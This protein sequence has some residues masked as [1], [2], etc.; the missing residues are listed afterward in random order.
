[1]EVAK[2]LAGYSLGDADLLRRAMGKKIKAEMDA[3]RER[4]VSGAV[5]RGLSKAQGERDLRPPRQVRRLRLQQEPR[6]RLR[7]RRL[8]DR[9]P[10]GEPSGRVPR[11]VDDARSLDNTDKLGEFRREAQR[12]GIRV[13]PPSVNRSGV[14]FDVHRRRAGDPLRARRRQ[15][16]R[17]AGRRGADRGARRQRLSRPRATSPGASTRGSSTSARSRASSRPGALDELEPDRARASAAVD[18]MMA[19]PSARSRPPTGGMDDMFGG[20]AAADVAAAHPA[21]RAVA[22]L[23]A[24]A[25][26][27]RRRRLLP[28]RPPARR[29]SA[30]G[31]RAAAGAE[32]GRFLPRREGRRS[33]GRVAAT[34]LDRYERRTKTGNKMGI[35][36]L[37]D[38]TGHFEA[39]V[40]SGGAAAVPRPPRARQRPSCSCSRPASRAT[41]SGP[42]SS[43][44]SRSTRRSPRH[45]KGMRIF[46]RDERADPQRRRAPARARRGRGVA[47]ADPR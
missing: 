31:A 27:I 23:G 33:V 38:Q 25:E 42:A 20:V 15:G 21:L 1:M 32:L 6:R 41:R 44:P 24:A 2:V 5:E 10:E 17:P 43:R 45:Q 34:V 14:D 13:E 12:L 39:I 4:F 16:R 8:P 35:V 30:T 18:A 29:V 3:Q 40:F 47:G 28:V 11:R 36:M 22:G 19:S 9:L 7:A 46:L 37:S 26:G